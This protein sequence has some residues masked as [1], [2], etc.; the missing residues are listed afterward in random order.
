[1]GGQ[2]VYMRCRMSF[3]A[4][5][6]SLLLRE[7]SGPWAVDQSRAPTIAGWAR[8]TPSRSPRVSGIGKE[9]PVGLP[10]PWPDPL[11]RRDARGVESLRDLPGAVAAGRPSKIFRTTGTSSGIG[12][13]PLSQASTR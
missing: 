11:S 10:A 3:V 6:F 13:S 2:V 9:Y 4:R 5:V 8:F 12:S 1:M 7:V